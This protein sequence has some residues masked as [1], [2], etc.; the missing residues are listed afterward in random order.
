MKR[1]SY[2]AAV[3]WVA[4]NDSAGE[5]T[6]LKVSEVS[7]LITVVLVAD[8]FGVEPEKVAR[9]VIRVRKGWPR[10]ASTKK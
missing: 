1:A 8:I 6:A 2:R 4:L 10:K 7:E 3:Q 9:A 5:D